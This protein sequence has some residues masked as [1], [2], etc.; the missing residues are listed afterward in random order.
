MINKSSSSNKQEGI[1][2]RPSVQGGLPF[3]Q[4]KSKEYVKVRFF[5]DQGIGI[6]KDL[7]FY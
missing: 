1:T 2:E 7:M 3:L 5:A 6:L 4:G